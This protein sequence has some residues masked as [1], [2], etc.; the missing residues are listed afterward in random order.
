MTHYAHRLQIGV[1]IVV[2]AQ[3]PENAVAAAHLAEDSGLDVVL[4]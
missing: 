2:G 3:S 4:F 1:E